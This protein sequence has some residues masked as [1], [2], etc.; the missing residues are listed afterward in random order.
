MQWVVVVVCSLLKRLPILGCSSV[1]PYVS[2][3]LD[4]GTAAVHETRRAASAGPH[5]GFAHMPQTRHTVRRPQLRLRTAARAHH[6][7]P[8]WGEV[9][10]PPDSVLVGG[11]LAWVNPKN[12]SQCPQP[13]LVPSPLT[14]C[15]GSDRT[16][17]GFQM[18]S[19]MR[20]FQCQY[21]RTLSTTFLWP[22]VFQCPSKHSRASKSM[23]QT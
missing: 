16:L 5:R 8:E 20:A 17:S 9:I 7:V 13:P 10:T 15:M 2:R 18:F 19:L 6:R 3:G 12:R 23:I 4:A 22:S 11:D 21:G 1:V 14:Y